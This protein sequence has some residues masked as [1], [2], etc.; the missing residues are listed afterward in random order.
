MFPPVKYKKLTM[1]ELSRSEKVKIIIFLAFIILFLSFFGN[2]SKK[3]CPS[4]T[5]KNSYKLHKDYEFHFR[6]K[7]EG[8]DYSIVNGCPSYYHN[9]IV[10]YR[11]VLIKVGSSNSVMDCNNNVILRVTEDDFLVNNTLISH[12]FKNLND[13]TIAYS[14]GENYDPNNIII[15]DMSDKIIAILRMDDLTRRKILRIDLYNQHHIMSDPSVLMA[16]FSDVLFESGNGD[17]CNL[18][19]FF[20]ITFLILVFFLILIL[21]AV[22]Y[23]NRER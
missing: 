4:Y 11:D 19:L 22:F 23:G 15:R 8:E 13:E 5:R 9:S 2:N 3:R 14:D 21:S 10:Y 12:R 6:E 17:M 1:S 20:F 7:Y 16:L 18:I